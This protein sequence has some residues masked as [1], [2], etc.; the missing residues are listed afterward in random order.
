MTRSSAP[1]A[2]ST[3][4][5]VSAAAKC[6]SSQRPAGIARITNSSGFTT[7]RS[8]TAPVETLQRGAGLVGDRGERQPQQLRARD[9]QAEG[10]QDRPAAGPTGRGR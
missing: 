2:V 8:P 9:E 7:A 6:R 10:D 4:P 3:A 5:A 1:A